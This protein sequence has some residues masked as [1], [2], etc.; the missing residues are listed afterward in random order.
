MVRR[1]IDTHLHF[2]DSEELPYPWLEADGLGALPARYLPADWLRDAAGVDVVGLVHVQAEVDHDTDPVRETAWITKLTEHVPLAVATIGYADLRSPQL[3]E[4][5][6]RHATA[7]PRFRGVRQEAWYDPESTR[8]DVPREN[9]LRDP[10]WER[11]LDELSRRGLLFELLVWQHQLPDARRIFAERPELTVVLEHTALPVESAACDAWRSELAAF[12]EAVPSAWLKISA[13]GFV[14][15]AWS[16]SVVD[17]V[18]REAISIAGPARCF[19][20][21]NYPVEKPGITYRGVWEAF[22]RST[23][24]LTEDELEAVFVLNAA[25]VYGLPA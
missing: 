13:L 2:W 6:D 21:S 24:D 23:S 14:D 3:A 11:G 22:Q 4:V 20:A 12:L 15:P 16:P 25:R 7:H 10:L 8:A 5:L 1:A 9:L 17:P 18:I 19:F